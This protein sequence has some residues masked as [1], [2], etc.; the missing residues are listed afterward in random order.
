[1]EICE[2]L[3][4]ERTKFEHRRKSYNCYTEWLQAQPLNIMD[5]LLNPACYITEMQLNRMFTLYEMY[6]MVSG[7]AGHIAEVGVLKGA[8]SMLF[9]KMVKLFE[10]EAFTCVHGFDSFTGK[11]SNPAESAMISQDEDY[12]RLCELAK[13]QDLDGI[14][15]IHKLD[16]LDDTLDF[17]AL[18]PQL[19]FKLVFMDIGS[20]DAMK[21]AIP[22]FWKHLLP[23]GIMVFDHFSLQAAPGETLALAEVLPSVIVRTLPNSWTPNAYIRKE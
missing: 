17:F 20:F 8:G 14:M 16:V 19:R 6:K 5:F 13:K 22:L 18:A 10:P 2:K 4:F 7:I 23:G 3:L 9:A 1:M 11:S 21:V 15:K 12:V